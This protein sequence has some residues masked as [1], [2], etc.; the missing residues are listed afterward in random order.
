M[1]VETKSAYL[2]WAF[3]LTPSPLPLGEGLLLA[4]SFPGEARDC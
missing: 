3:S 4:V 2:L 1:R